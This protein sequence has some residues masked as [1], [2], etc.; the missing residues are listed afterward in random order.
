MTPIDTL[1]ARGHVASAEGRKAFVSAELF[2][3]E[4]NLLA[5][6]N[7]LMVRLLPGTAV[8]LTPWRRDSSHDYPAVR[9]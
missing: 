7:G 6:S 3:P 2:D 1:T 9:I 8:A 4:G 5:E